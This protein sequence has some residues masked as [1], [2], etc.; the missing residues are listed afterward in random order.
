M[1]IFP[2]PGWVSFGQISLFFCRTFLLGTLQAAETLTGLNLLG[3]R[4]GAYEAGLK[5]QV[6]GVAETGMDMSPI[7][8]IRNYVLE[9]FV[10]EDEQ[11]RVYA[12][13]WL[14][15]ERRCSTAHSALS[16]AEACEAVFSAALAILGSPLINQE[17][18]TSRAEGAATSAAENSADAMAGL[19]RATQARA[20][21][22]L[23]V[24]TVFAQ[25]WEESGATAHPDYKDRL[26]AFDSVTAAAL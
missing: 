25:W 15:M 9:H 7:D 11:R 12:E 5:S 26:A 24:Y 21:A 19:F 8:L 10:T 22:R 23:Q 2:F 20:K 1:C 6:K 18:S 3:P 13:L 4:Y 14:P 16:T 17:S